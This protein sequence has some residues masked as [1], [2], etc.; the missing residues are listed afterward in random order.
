MDAAL[1]APLVALWMQTTV[2]V[3]QLASG[4]GGEITTISYFREH[5]YKVMFKIFQKVIAPIPGSVIIRFDRDSVHFNYCKVKSSVPCSI[6]NYAPTDEKNPHKTIITSIEDCELTGEMN[7]HI[8][9]T[10]TVD[11]M[12]NVVPTIAKSSSLK[13]ERVEETSSEYPGTKVKV[14]PGLIN[15]NKQ[16]IAKRATTKKARVD[17]P[18]SELSGTK[19]K[20]EPGLP[21]HTKST[22][23]KKSVPKKSIEITETPTSAGDLFATPAK[24]PKKARLLEI[25][26]NPVDTPTQNVIGNLT[27]RNE[28]PFWNGEQKIDKKTYVWWRNEPISFVDIDVNEVHKLIYIVSTPNC[29]VSPFKIEWK[30]QESQYDAGDI[31]LHL[32]YD[33]LSF[34][35]HHGAIRLENNL[36]LARYKSDL[37]RNAVIADDAA[38]LSELHAYGICGHAKDPD[39]KCIT[40]KKMR[41]S[42]AH[43]SFVA[44]KNI[45]CGHH[46]T[47]HRGGRCPA[48]GY[49]GFTEESIEMFLERNT[50]TIPLGLEIS[51]QCFH[52]KNVR[53]KR[54]QGKTA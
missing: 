13:K 5:D 44:Y 17:E 2:M 23:A 11:S 38:A 9:E 8:T 51:P 42:R 29:S 27:P 53:L 4:G 46:K 10:P 30:E 15:H 14:E 21:G 47:K 6:A 22:I 43:T 32:L 40:A 7:L 45:Y 19:V 18:V 31:I 24:A 16:T 12:S 41:K 54:L 33:G 49:I 35:R 52:Q 28:N 50:S 3:Y 26:P 25:H 34:L 48:T 36:V 1:V 37:L 39:G 20:V